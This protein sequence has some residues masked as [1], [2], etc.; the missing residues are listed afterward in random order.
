MEILVPGSYEFTDD[1]S[2]EIEEGL[3]RKPQ[4][5]GGELESNNENGPEK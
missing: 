3:R 1:E 2:K 4:L 5:E